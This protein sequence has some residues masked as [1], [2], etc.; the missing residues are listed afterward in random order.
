MRPSRRYQ[1]PGPTKAGNSPYQILA[2]SGGG[3]RGLFTA[4]ILEQLEQRAGR[5]LA[6]CFDIIAGTSI[7][8]I[9]ACG[10]I[11]GV[12]ASAIRRE[13]ERLGD[14][15]FDRHL[16]VFGRRLFP[17]PR[18]GLMSTRYSREGLA[19][20]VNSVLQHHA[21]QTLAQTRPGLIVPA[22]SATNGEPYIFET[23]LPNDPHGAT[24][25]RDVAFA[26]SAAP[27]YFPE[28][29]IRS[30]AL[31]DGG[32]IA[33]APDVIALTR[34]LSVAGRHPDEIRLLSIGT[35]GSALGEVFKPGRRSGVLGWMI[36]RNLFGLTISAQESLALSMAKEL[37]GNRYVRIDA[38]ADAK[39]EKAIGLDKAGHTATTT[40]K[41]LAAE[42]IDDVDRDS[43]SGPMLSTLLRR[44]PKT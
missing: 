21:R 16:T 13:F 26:T 24:T 27:T 43:T 31:V 2:L 33:N 9:L 42:A 11:A 15:V 23:G 20:A 34:A 39:R 30:N 8:G 32:L 35:A 12:P 1:R 25:L 6:E 28:H 29:E 22:V 36:A 10:L 7:G 17:I 41:G 5:P 3:Y 18:L 40:L 38:V 14:H 4:I 37:L 44:S 19:D